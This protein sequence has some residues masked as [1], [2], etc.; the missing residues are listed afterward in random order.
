MIQST[1]KCDN[2]FKCNG[3]SL[4]GNRLWRKKINEKLLRQ[5][6]PEYFCQK[7]STKPIT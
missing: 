1:D 7:N 3:K 6:H 5:I 4:Y 2:Y